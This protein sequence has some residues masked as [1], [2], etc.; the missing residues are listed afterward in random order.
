MFDWDAFKSEKFE[1]V[2]ET[3]NE[4]RDFLNKCKEQG[5]KFYDD[6]K[7][8][9]DYFNNTF[10]VWRS[11]YGSGYV[12][13]FLMINN[14]LSHYFKKKSDNV[15]NR[16]YFGN[17]I[18]NEQEKATNDAVDLSSLDFI[19]DSKINRK[20]EEKLKAL[21]ILNNFAKTILGGF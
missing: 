4:A 7:E 20:L 9:N 18:D 21:G 8:N 5:I 19:I 10:N 14:H 13:I 16:I 11:D 2:C 17:F 1:I 3:I 12:C 6:E 15:L